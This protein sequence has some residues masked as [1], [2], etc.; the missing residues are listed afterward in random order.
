MGISQR[1]KKSDSARKVVPSHGMRKE[2]AQDALSATTRR[3]LVSN[4]RRD[5]NS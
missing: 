3:I 2:I 1:A 4:R 5:T